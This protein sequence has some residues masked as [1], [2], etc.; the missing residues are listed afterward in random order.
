MH[1][2]SDVIKLETNNKNTCSTQDEVELRISQ[3]QFKSFFTTLTQESCF[4]NLIV[5]V[6]S[7][8]LECS[9]ADKYVV[10]PSTNF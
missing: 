9:S 1:H 10:F 2:L 4:D 3:E 7:F 6:D 8:L 5:A